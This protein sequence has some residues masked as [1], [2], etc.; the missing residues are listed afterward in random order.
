MQSQLPPSYVLSNML[1]FDHCWTG[2]W[3]YLKKVVENRYTAKCFYYK[4]KLY[5][6]SDKLHNYVL[7]CD[8][9][10]VT[11]KNSYIIK[12]TS[13]TPKSCKKSLISSD[14][15]QFKIVKNLYFHEFLKELASNYSPPSA[16]TLSTRIFN[17][18]F[19]TYLAKKFKVMLSLTD[20]TV[21][22]DDATNTENLNI[23]LLFEDEL[24]E[25]PLEFDIEAISVA[26]DNEK[27]VIEEF[28]DVSTF[29]Q[30]QEIIDEDLNSMTYIQKFS[31]TKNWLI[32]DIFFQSE[33]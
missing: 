27:L 3:H 15:E 8:N 23:D 25:E 14:Q 10:P 4:Y 16:K 17:N 33:A 21:A 7:T 22:L 5:G 12:V 32:D 11:K 13:L 28:F 9:W 26:M 24:F 1:F 29:K 30:N 2:F 6:R 19:L 18:S 31:S 20:I